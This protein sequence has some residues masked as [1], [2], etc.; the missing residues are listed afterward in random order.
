MKPWLRLLIANIVL[1]AL[2]VAPWTMG[3]LDPWTAFLG[4]LIALPVLNTVSLLIYRDPDA[5]KPFSNPSWRRASYYARFATVMGVM[6]AL[7]E[8]CK[9]LFQFP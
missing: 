4:I 3:R 7:Y 1:V 2:I 5:R 9:W 6:F 8:Y